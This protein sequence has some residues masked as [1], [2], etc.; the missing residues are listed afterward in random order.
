[1]APPKPLLTATPDDVLRTHDSLQR[2]VRKAKSAPPGGGEVAYDLSQ[3]SEIDPGAVLL[4]M[5]AGAMLGAAGWSAFATGDSPAMRK[6]GKNLRHLRLS[7]EDR[8]TLQIDVGEYPLRT[9]AERTTMVAELE[10]W[11]NTVRQGTG[12][13][14]EE[15]ATWSMQISEVITNGF[16]HGATNLERPF[17]EMLLIGGS[18]GA[19]VQLAA[20]DRGAGIPRV[21]E[22]YVASAVAN[23]GDGALIKEA[24]RP[25]VTSR[26]SPQNQGYGLPH[27]VDSVKRNGGTL[28]IFS[29]RGFVR[30][31]NSRLTSRNF[32]RSA[33]RLDGTLTIIS[34]NVSTRAGVGDGTGAGHGN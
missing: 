5:Y 34:L 17:P 18:D 7:P 10:D 15:V 14:P 26:C 2:L 30:V 22:K 3:C 4:M 19:R 12:A 29:Q 31:M 28:Q 13:K 21:I 9:V 25:G 8:K 27:L 33:R 20:L 1:V 16:Q 23:K 32:N 24:C 11:A 6:L